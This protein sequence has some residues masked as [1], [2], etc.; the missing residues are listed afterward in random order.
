VEMHG[1]TV[2]MH[3][4]TVEMHGTTVKMHGT[5]ENAWY[6]CENQT[7]TSTWKLCISN[8]DFQCSSALYFVCMCP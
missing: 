6:K 5:T 2:K 1:T 7:L 4:T 8:T 3:G